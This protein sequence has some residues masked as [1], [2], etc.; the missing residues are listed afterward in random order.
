[1]ENNDTPSMTD[2]LMASKANNDMKAVFE[3]LKKI[4]HENLIRH[5][6]FVVDFIYNYKRR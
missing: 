3:R 5:K 6:E 2:I 1:M 4:N